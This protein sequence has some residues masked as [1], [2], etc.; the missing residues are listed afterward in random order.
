MGLRSFVKVNRR[1][2]LAE[3]GQPVRNRTPDGPRSLG[4]RRADVMFWSTRWT[5]PSRGRFLP[6]SGWPLEAE[7]R[8]PS[9][10]PDR[11]G[12]RRNASVVLELW[13]PGHS[14]LSQQNEEYD[15]AQWACQHKQSHPWR[16]A[17]IL[18]APY[19]ERQRGDKRDQM[20]RLKPR[21]RRS[22]TRHKV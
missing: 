10:R 1:Q 19:E 12:H 14:R 2:G 13:C 4:G 11:I 9:W 17:S 3:T 7:I 8:R 22:G 5:A 16:V 6:D 21:W 20:S 18:Q 15:G